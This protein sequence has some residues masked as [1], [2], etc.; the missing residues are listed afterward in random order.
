MSFPLDFLSHNS[1]FAVRYHTKKG[2]ALLGR[3]SQLDLVTDDPPRANF[4]SSRKRPDCKSDSMD[5]ED[6]RLPQSL[7]NINQTA[8]M[9]H[10]VQGKVDDVWEENGNEATAT[11][12]SVPTHLTSIHGST[13]EQRLKHK[14]ES[15]DKDY[16]G[17]HTPQCEMDGGDL[18]ITTALPA[19]RKGA[20]CL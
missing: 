4:L 5:E 12:S 8:D 17:E 18:A 16:D 11:A 15:A 19:N 1:A 10:F 14:L 7:G 2:N 20:K 6:G 13:F 9:G 3:S